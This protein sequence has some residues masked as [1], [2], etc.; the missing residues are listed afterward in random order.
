MAPLG[1][2]PGPAWPCWGIAEPSTGGA[3]A[4]G[5]CG[6]PRDS[7]EP[8]DAQPPQTSTAASN[9]CLQG[10]LGAQG[11][12]EQ[13]AGDGWRCG[14]C[15]TGWECSGCSLPCAAVGDAAPAP[16]GLVGRGALGCVGGLALLGQWFWS[17]EL[18]H[19]LNMHSLERGRNK[20]KDP[21][22]SHLCF[23][24][25][26]EATCFW[27]VANHWCT[28]ESALRGRSQN[29]SFFLPTSSLSLEIQGPEFDKV[30]QTVPIPLRSP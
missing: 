10:V 14:T 22:F 26:M 13:D 1:A 4:S 29:E 30:A 15:P 3:G 7:P 21:F 8:S 12:G 24:D 16:H 11:Q 2:H 28:C 25:L 20:A 9:S 19:N 23:N 17:A 18:C 27:A 5:H 6:A